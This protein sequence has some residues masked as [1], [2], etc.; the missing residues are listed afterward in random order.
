[1]ILSFLIFCFKF[2]VELTKIICE[3]RYNFYSCLL[4]NHKVSLSFS[5]LSLSLSPSLPLFY[6]FYI[7]IHT[8]IHSFTHPY[9]SIHTSIHTSIRTSIRTSIHHLYTSTSI[10]LHT[11]IHSYTLIHT[12]THPHTPPARVRAGCAVLSLGSAGH[13]GGGYLN[14]AG[15]QEENLFRRTTLSQALETVAEFR[16]TQKL[17]P[18]Y[19]NEGIFCKNVVV[20]RGP[21]S[22][23]FSLKS[24]F[25]SF[26]SFSSFPGF[27][28]EFCFSLSDPDV[29]HHSLFS[30][31]FLVCFSHL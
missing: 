3:S 25:L 31:L 8:L 9:T 27:I 4:I 5:L 6:H 26:P 20:F 19:G 12:P 11:P 24:T 30:L 7:H 1:M 29:I 22:V 14:G 23:C 2:H 10:Y 21:E 15:A 17:Y 28:C 18:I 16:R 13:P